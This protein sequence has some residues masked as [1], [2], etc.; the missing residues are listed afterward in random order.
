M[1]VLDG[2]KLAKKITDEAED[3]RRN[4]KGEA[5]LTAKNEIKIIKE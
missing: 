4:M 5:E 1:S 3:M 2:E